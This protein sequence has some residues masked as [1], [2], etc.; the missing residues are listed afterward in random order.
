MVRGRLCRALVARDK[1]SKNGPWPV[2][3]RFVA[4]FN[5][6]STRPVFEP[7]S[8]VDRPSPWASRRPSV[9]ILS[10]GT[11][12]GGRWRNISATTTA[13]LAHPLRGHGEVQRRILNWACSYTLFPRP[14]FF[15]PA[16]PSRAVK[17]F[18]PLVILLQ[19]YALKISAKVRLLQSFGTD[20]ETLP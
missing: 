12:R 20:G 1:S 6:S 3:L 16:G 9:D 14:L 8:R 18:V 19:K 13:Q 7:P 5:R 17:M 4:K 11:V 10:H 15:T 2:V